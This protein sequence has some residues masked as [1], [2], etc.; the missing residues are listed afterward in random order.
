MRTRLVVGRDK[1]PYYEDA[2]SPTTSLLV[3]KI[4]SNSVISHSHLGGRFM[5]L[6]LEDHLLASPMPKPNFMKIP[7]KYRKR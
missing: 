5:A 7:A 4:L 3:C 6:D 1:L 2:G